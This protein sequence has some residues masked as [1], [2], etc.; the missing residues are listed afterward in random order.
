MC[1]E[2]KL[3]VCSDKSLELYIK[4]LFKLIGIYLSTSNFKLVDTTAIIENTQ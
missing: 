1:K 4:D 3:F 2:E